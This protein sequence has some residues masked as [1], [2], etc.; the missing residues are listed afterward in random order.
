LHRFFLDLHEEAR[1]IES[2]SYL[3]DGQGLVA[4]KRVASNIHSV[5]TA[6][7]SDEMASASDSDSGDGRRPKVRRETFSNPKVH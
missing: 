5:C 1:E 4:D 6:D 7:D 3:I 2:L